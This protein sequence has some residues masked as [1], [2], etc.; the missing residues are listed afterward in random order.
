ML[1]TQFRPKSWQD[2]VGNE[3]AVN[4][5]RGALAIQ[6][7]EIASGTAKDGL[8]IAICGLSGAGKTSLAQLI[9][10][11]SG[12]AP[13]SMDYEELDGVDCDERAVRNLQQ[14]G[15]FLST[16]P[17]GKAKVIIVNEYHDMTKGAVQAWLT[18]LER[19][20]KWAI[21]IFTTTEAGDLFGN[22]S[23]PFARR[24]VNIALSNQGLAGLFAQRLVTIAAAKGMELPHKTA[25]AMVQAVA[26]NLGRAIEDLG[27]L[28]AERVKVAA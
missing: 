12:A 19:L 5:A 1:H 22:F 11:E 20:P 17:W 16:R 9:A 14:T 28:L 21:V 26:N 7:T 15:G 25:L 27:K 24:C 10:M 23:G 8:A 4:Q 3:R 6:Q 18:L 2:F 13:G